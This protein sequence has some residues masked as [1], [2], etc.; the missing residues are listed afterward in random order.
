[1]FDLASSDALADGI[2]SNFHLNTRFFTSA[3]ILVDD[4]RGESDLFASYK[5]LLVFLAQRV[6]TISWDVDQ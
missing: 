1:M 3:Q 4:C 2:I 6:V 5:D